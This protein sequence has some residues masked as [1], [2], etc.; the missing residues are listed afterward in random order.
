[1]VQ[2]HKAKDDL[3]K[4]IFEYTKP[5]PI[6]KDMEFLK[7]MSNILGLTIEESICLRAK[8]H[9]DNEVDYRRANSLF[10]ESNLTFN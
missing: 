7:H 1:M 10:R 9:K 3:P 5:E 4:T 8:R 6:D 2:N